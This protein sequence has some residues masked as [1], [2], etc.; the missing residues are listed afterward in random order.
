MVGSFIRFAVAAAFS[1]SLGACAGSSDYGDSDYGA[2]ADDSQTL[3]CV[4]YARS[5]SG[6]AIFGDAYTWW[7]K[8]A[9]RFARQSDPHLGAVMVLDNYAGPN[10]AH[11]AVVT[12]MD[13]NRVIKVDHANWL[14]DGAII[15]DDPVRDVSDD[16]DWSAVQVWNPRTR[17]WGTRV[18]SV[19]GFI[20]PGRDIGDVTADA[21]S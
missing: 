3:Q 5:V 4:P 1:L 14:N 6:V 7:D 9:G 16:N 13:S 17:A 2:R 12:T 10:R 15:R 11:L 8:A 18:Y 21:G 20:G 19:R